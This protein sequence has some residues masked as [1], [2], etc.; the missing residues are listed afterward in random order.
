MVAAAIRTIFAQPHAQRVCEQLDAI[1]AIHQPARTRKQGDQEPHRPRRHIPNPAS[2]P[3]LAVADIIETHEA[4]RV[5]DRRCLSEAFMAQIGT[6]APETAKE[7]AT[8]ELTA[9]RSNHHHL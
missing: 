3:R 8:P 1:A 2:M 9:S 6:T 4:Y 7:V 5:T